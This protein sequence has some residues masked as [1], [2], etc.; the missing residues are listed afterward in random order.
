V[1]E[2]EKAVVV[3]VVV[4]SWR[5]FVGFWGIDGSITGNK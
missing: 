1:S 5:T 4:E 2:A 3:V